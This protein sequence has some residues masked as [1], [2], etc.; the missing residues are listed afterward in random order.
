[1]QFQRLSL[2]LLHYFNSFHIGFQFTYLGTR[3]LPVGGFHC[4]LVPGQNAT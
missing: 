2:D 4:E 1:M 3:E